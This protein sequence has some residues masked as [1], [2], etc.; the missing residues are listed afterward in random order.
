MPKPL[1]TS[2]SPLDL[3]TARDYVRSEWGVYARYGWMQFQEKGRGLIVHN[4]HDSRNTR[5]HYLTEPG[6]LTSLDVVGIDLAELVGG[7]DPTTSVV[8]MITKPFTAAEEKRRAALSEA[9]FEELQE[10]IELL[11]EA[12][13]LTRREAAGEASASPGRLPIVTAGVYSFEPAPMSV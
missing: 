7:Y 1:F 12:I 6:R 4:Q 11:E 9:D 2:P 3:E 8:V 13:E 5:L 10:H